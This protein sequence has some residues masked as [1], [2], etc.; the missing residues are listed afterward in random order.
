MEA[1]VLAAQELVE[2]FRSL[3]RELETFKSDWEGVISRH[4]ITLNIGEIRRIDNEIA[5][6]RNK[7]QE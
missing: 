3:S 2:G 6:L 7:I 1:D 4:K 5:A